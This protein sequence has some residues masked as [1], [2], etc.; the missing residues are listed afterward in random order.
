MAK[1]ARDTEFLRALERHGRNP[2]AIAAELGLTYNG[3]FHYFRK[4]NVPEGGPRVAPQK[5]A[6]RDRPAP[7]TTRRYLVTS[8]QSCTPVWHPFW[9]NLLAF[10]EHHG[11]ADE[12][13]LIGRF[14]YNQN[15]FGPL[16]VK[17]G[18]SKHAEQRLWFADEVEPFAADNA[19]ELGPDL[20]WCGEL[21]ILPT[22][23]NPLSGLANYT[24]RKSMI[25]PHAKVRLE[26]VPTAR[27]HSAKMCYTTGTVTQQNYVEKK[28]GQKA[29]F[30][31][32]Y[33]ALIVE[34]TSNGAWFVRQLNADGDGSFYDL[35]LH[36]ADEK[37]T[38]S[39][40]VEA[41]NLGDLHTRHLD[42]GVADLAWRGRGSMTDT[43]LPHKIIVH[44]L[45]DS[46]ARNPHDRKDCHR[47][48]RRHVEGWDGVAAEV[49]QA[50]N[51]LN[52]LGAECEEVV[53]VNSN[54]DDMLR[55]WLRDT[56]YRLD[57]PNAEFFLALQL[58]IYQAIRK[59]EADDFHLLEHAMGG[60][61][62]NARFLRE[63]ESY[64]ICDGRIECGQHGHLGP[65][66]S[67]GTPA[68]LSKMGARMNTGHTHSAAIIDGM[69]VA[70][71]SSKLRLI[72]NSGP[73]SW[74]HSHIVTYPNGK[75]TIV[76]MWDG[77]WRG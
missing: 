1:P 37:V 26:S 50:E 54:H 2:A 10:K 46:Y 77:A 29:R 47:M 8:A 16:S 5:A 19:I 57:P 56:D 48:F 17:P 30:H 12:D 28:E 35:D 65:S 42:S 73:G 23:V 15:R 71:T 68:A 66:G 27:D 76:T 59:G 40:R 4:F 64:T 75:R 18:K 55:T 41:I 44:D 58:E 67:R 63:D 61:P 14:T 52:E 20:I 43:L 11:I 38:A 36:V 21:N 7:G 25:V 3:V 34:V 72:Y 45:L 32:I 9:D 22:A 39:H 62:I 69:Y 53:V 60:G 33:G 24:S 31:H 70:G 49:D 13:F 51:V 74:S 6:R